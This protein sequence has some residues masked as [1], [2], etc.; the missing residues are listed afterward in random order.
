MERILIFTES[1]RRNSKACQSRRQ[2]AF[3]VIFPPNEPG[4]TTFPYNS[5]RV[6]FGL[7]VDPT[8]EP[9][10]R[11]ELPLRHDSESHGSSIAQASS[12]PVDTA[13]SHMEIQVS[14]PAFDVQ[15]EQVFFPPDE[16]AAPAQE[17]DERILRTGKNPVEFDAPVDESVV[18]DTVIDFLEYI[19]MRAQSIKPKRLPSAH[20]VRQQRCFILIYTC[21]TGFI[22]SKK[23]T[24]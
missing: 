10:E 4:W 14:P 3:D 1:P 6:A 21:K 5:W 18:P 15:S 20:K 8:P 24:S 9:L 2:F 11:L 16:S 23:E 7:D 19:M 17:E 22:G 13:A 12:P